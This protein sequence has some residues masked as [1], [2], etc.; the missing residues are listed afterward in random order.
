MKNNCDVSGEHTYCRVTRGGRKFLEC[1]FRKLDEREWCLYLQ[2]YGSCINTAAI[3]AAIEEEHIAAT[4][5]KMDAIEDTAFAR[6]GMLKAPC[7]KCGYNGEKY[8]YP[9]VHKCA[10]KHHRLYKYNHIP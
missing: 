5:K 9:D 7:F 4:N 2:R 10:E 6:G 3:R 1:D 8:F